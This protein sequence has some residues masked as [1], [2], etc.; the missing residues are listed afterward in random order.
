[1]V[2]TVG[3]TRGNMSFPSYDLYFM[4]VVSFQFK[5]AVSSSLFTS[6]Y[7]CNPYP[8]NVENMVSS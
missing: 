1:M 7:Y 2:M 8:A 5:D 6:V 3:A 4:T